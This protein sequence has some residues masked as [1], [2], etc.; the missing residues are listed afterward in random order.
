[1]EGTW[2]LGQGQLTLKQEFQM[3][4]GTLGNTPISDGRLRGNEITFKAG[5]TQYS[6]R[7]NSNAIEGTAGNQTWKAVRAQ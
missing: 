5:N 3:I 6:G 1:V 7:V 4:S 2:R